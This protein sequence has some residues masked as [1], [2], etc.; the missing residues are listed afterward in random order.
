MNSP[1]M[2]VRGPNASANI[3]GTVV[4]S[5]GQPIKDVRIEVRKVSTGEIVASGY[6][7]PGGSFSLDNIAP[8]HYEVRGTSGLQ[9]ASQRVDLDPLGRND[10]TLRISG[11]VAGDNSGAAT[12][13]MYE[14]R[15]PEKAK[16]EYE[17]ASEAFKKQKL[18]DARQHCEKALKADPTYSRALSLGA[19]LDVLGNNLGSAQQQAEQSVKSDPG[20]GM[21]YVVLGAIYNSLQRYNDAA[22][23]LDHAMPLVPNS[24]QAHFEMSRALLGKGEY[25]QALQQ[26]DRALQGAPE[27]YAPAHL[28]RAHVLLGLKAYDDA[29]SELEKCI[30][31]DP[32]G[33]NSAVARRALGEVKS[34]MATA[35]K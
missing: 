8:G 30:G 3:S 35:K 2:S 22:M 5:D 10:V 20:Y 23:T 17:K 18:D 21:G 33:A 14:L 25:R 19:L 31:A 15:V 27:N 28:V 26:I 12:V 9:E 13:S 6:T 11:P 32:N 1:D 16:K 34:F 24:W 29:V 7:L 4:S